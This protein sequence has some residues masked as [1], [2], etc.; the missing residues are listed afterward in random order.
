MPNSWCTPNCRCREVVHGELDANRLVKD[1]RIE[2]QI[3]VGHRAVLKIERITLTLFIV[4][5]V[6]KIILIARSIRVSIKA[7]K[8]CAEFAAAGLSCGNVPFL[9]LVFVIH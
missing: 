6:D 4:I 2:R 8:T 5:P 3:T 9:I 1:L 7:C